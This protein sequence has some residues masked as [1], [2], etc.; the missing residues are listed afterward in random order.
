MNGR[1]IVVALLTVGVFALGVLVWWMRTQPASSTLSAPS[2]IVSP[3]A[4]P[5]TRPNIVF[6]SI[7]AVRP[8]HLSSYGYKKNTSPNIDK[9]AAQGI[10]FEYCLAQA[11]WTLPSHMSLFTSMLPTQNGV[12]NLNKTLPANFT[13]LAQ[14]LREEGYRTAG[15]VNNGQMRA[16]W[17]FSRGF[18]VWN[19]YEVDT[20]QADADQ[21]TDRALEWL[22]DNAGQPGPYFLFL[23][24]YD[25]HDPYEAP[26][27]WRQKFGTTLTGEQSRELAFAN[28]TPA[29]NITDRAV[30]DDLVSAYDAEIAYMDHELGRLFAALPPDTMI[31]LFSDHGECFEETGWT[32]HGATLTDPDIRTALIVRPP[33]SANTKPQHVAGT[34]ML[35]DVAPTL[36]SLAGLKPHPQ[37]QGADLSPLW[38]NPSA[39]FAHRSILSET[40]AVIEGRYLLRVTADHLN[41][42]YSLFDGTFETVLHTPQNA[43]AVTHSDTFDPTEALHAPLKQWIRGE[44]FWM[45]HASGSG[46]HEV[47][48][49][50]PQS[51]FA[52]YIPVNL[53]GERDSFEISPDSK[54]IRWHIYPGASPL[55][56]SLFLQTAN[57]DA[58]LEFDYKHNGEAVPK[59]THLGDQQTNPQSLPVTLDT[60]LAPSD[61]LILTP[62]PV[63]PNGL[64]ITRHADPT[65]PARATQVTPLDEETLR[66]LR[67]L[68]Y[69]Q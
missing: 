19:E 7:D 22:R 67:S 34:V 69:I 4:A 35:M 11:P 60:A 61:P 55:R 56:K 51:P 31:I 49:R 2:A 37:F 45:L 59:M 23:H 3:N 21:L 43:G 15:I 17:G 25:A 24:Y 57:P 54:T 6:I 39:P 36:L 18:D 29:N 13:T 47:I 20:P 33:A 27:V 50:S 30:L 5:T 58:P 44:R 26:A 65:Q 42:T 16:H 9:I 52:I 10:L 12:D 46:D 40:K 63:V 41:A 28:R 32:L 8:D 64:H 53:E 66:Q 1:P 38:Q 68:G 48:I 62:F 14:V